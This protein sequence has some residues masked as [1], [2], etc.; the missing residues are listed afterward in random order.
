MKKDSKN[1]IAS[2]YSLALYEA[3]ESK[4]AVEEVYADIL[5]LLEVIAADKDFKRYF[6]NPLWSLDSKKE[7]LRDIAAKLKLSEETKCC[8]D[9]IA[10]NNRFAEFDMILDAFKH[11]Y[12]DKKNIEEVN[13]QS[14]KKLSASQ[15]KKLVSVLEKKLGKKVLVNYI[16]NPELLGGLKISYGSNMIDD[17]ISGKLTRLENMMKGGQ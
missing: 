14:V 13:V 3:A 15:N 7:A 16:L 11:L 8:L 1:K 4:K 17:S 6:T 2:V 9:V 5:V 12:Y 10:D